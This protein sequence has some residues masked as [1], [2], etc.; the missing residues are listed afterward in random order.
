MMK[1]FPT[2]KMKFRPEATAPDRGSV[3]LPQRRRWINPTIHDVV[4]LV[5]LPN[6]SGFCLFWTRFIVLVMIF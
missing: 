1:H 2:L 3:L 6:L 5:F 4:E